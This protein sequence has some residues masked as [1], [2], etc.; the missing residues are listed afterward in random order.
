MS[1]RDEYDRLVSESK[2]AEKTPERI[3]REEEY[4]LLTSLG[5]RLG[6]W[7][8]RAFGDYS[9]ESKKANTFPLKD[10]DGEGIEYAQLIKEGLWKSTSLEGSPYKIA[11]EDAVVVKCRANFVAHI[12][13]P[14]GGHY[15]FVPSGA[16]TDF[17]GG[18][19]AT[20]FAWASYGTNPKQPIGGI[21]NLL[22]DRKVIA[23]NRRRQQEA[24]ETARSE[25]AARMETI[26]ELA[27]GCSQEF[28][29]INVGAPIMFRDGWVLPKG[30]TLE[31]IKR[32]N[33]D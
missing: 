6:M 31:V 10:M 19:E 18:F 17:D 13:T 22:Y 2:P 9:Q 1:L 25:A 23:G 21:A 33:G 12:R 4:R 8:A 15:A 3:A 26:R 32:L 28:V 30:I 29:C 7:A 27:Q 5:C 16:L 11:L 14:Q 20:S 24:L